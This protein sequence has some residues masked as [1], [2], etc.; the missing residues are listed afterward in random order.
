MGAQGRVAPVR[1]V[2][3]TNVVL[4]ALLFAGG[5]L[6]W[7]RAAWQQGQLAPLVNQQTTAELLRVLTYP[8][9]RLGPAERE[10]LLADYLPHCEIVGPQEPL[11]LPAVRDSA[12]TMF[13]QL[14][15]TARAAYLVTGDADLLNLARANLPVPVSIMTPE[16]L[17]V[18]LQKG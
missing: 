5:R 13:L 8:K 6:Q 11:A 16:Q 12:D 3:D 4:S 14:A 7:L 10:E 15:C 18:A 9:F 1:V 17:R 2:L